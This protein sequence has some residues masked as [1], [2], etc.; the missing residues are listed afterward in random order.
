MDYIMDT[1]R[2]A[3]LDG[4]FHEHKGKLDFSERRANVSDFRYSC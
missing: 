3:N 4:D 2:T 1:A